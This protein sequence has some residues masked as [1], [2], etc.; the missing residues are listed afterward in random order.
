MGQL[1]SLLALNRAVARRFEVVNSTADTGVEATIYLYDMIVSNDWEAEWYGGVTPMMFITE[2][3]NITADTVHLRINSPGGD[4]FG[5]RVIEQAIRESNKTI[6]A[7]IDGYCASAATYIALAC[8][9]VIIASGGMFM[10]HNAWTMAWG[11]KTDLTKTATLLGK[12]DSTL[13]ATYAAK[14]G[15]TV[16]EIAAYMDAETWFTAQEAVDVGFVDE[17]SAAQNGQN[18]T[19]NASAWNMSVY[20]NAPKPAKPAPKQEQQPPEPKTPD[21]APLNFDREAAARRLA[22]ALI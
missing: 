19:Q 2:L 3:A 12:I 22:V 13:A 17:I 1:Y 20:R 7:H 14:T 10:I 11:D 21:P 4:V 9:K 16:E 6:I 8:S 18:G 15:K 5:A